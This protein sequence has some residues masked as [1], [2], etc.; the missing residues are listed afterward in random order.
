MDYVLGYRYEAI[1]ST[2]G[3]VDRLMGIA[4]FQ[5]EDGTRPPNDHWLKTFNF[6]EYGKHIFGPH[7]NGLRESTYVPIERSGNMLTADSLKITVVAD[8]TDRVPVVPSSSLVKGIKNYW[9]YAKKNGKLV[10]AWQ[11]TEYTL[12]NGIVK[13]ITPADKNVTAAM[14]FGTSA[15]PAATTTAPTP[16]APAKKG[17]FEALFDWL[18]GWL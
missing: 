15:T 13:T 5:N 2:T 3:P 18:F 11:K 10:L 1:A 17:F 7:Q 6:Q 4:Y 16:A 12:D 9:M 14:L 8:D